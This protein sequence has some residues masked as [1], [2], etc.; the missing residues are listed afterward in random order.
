MNEKRKTASGVATTESGSGKNLTD[1]IDYSNKNQ[2]KMQ[3]IVEQNLFKGAENAI[4][5]KDLVKIIGC[6]TTRRLQVLV[7]K[8]RQNGALILSSEAGYFL[9]SDGIKGRDEIIRFIATYRSMA[10][11]TL[12]VLKSAKQALAITNGQMDIRTWQ[13]YQE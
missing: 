6:N 4:S 7:S 12:K 9:P 5:G 3:G 13:N 2:A 8:E 1:D 11:N 10:L